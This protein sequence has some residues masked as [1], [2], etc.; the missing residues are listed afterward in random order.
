[1]SPKPGEAPIDVDH[2][3]DTPT[4]HSHFFSANIVNTHP[5]SSS[6]RQYQTCI[7]VFELPKSAQTQ[8]G[9]QLSDESPSPYVAWANDRV[10]RKRLHCRLT[11]AR[12]RLSLCIFSSCLLGSWQD[13]STV[14]MYNDGPPPS[15]TRSAIRM[16]S[17]KAS[18]VDRFTSLPLYMTLSSLLRTTTKHRS[19]R[20]WVTLPD[21][22]AM[23]SSRPTRPSQ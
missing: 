22:G 2:S 9:T 12:S 23:Q 18:F 16:K 21:G 11:S 14:Q 5:V 4:S 8:L 7:S 20:Y 17:T 6:P 1:M 13:G 19:P 10:H 3:L 15:Y